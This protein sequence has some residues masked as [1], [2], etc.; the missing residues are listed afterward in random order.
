MNSN[1][2]F[3]KLWSEIKV[4]A[5]PALVAM[6]ASGL[7]FMI[8]GNPDFSGI[9][10]FVLNTL[11][12]ALVI[13]SSTLTLFLYAIYFASS[14]L[15]EFMITDYSIV[16]VFLSFYFAI[17]VSNLVYEKDSKIRKIK[18]LSKTDSYIV[19]ASTLFIVTIGTF[20]IQAVVSSLMHI[21][22]SFSVST[23]P[24]ANS[25]FFGVSSFF[26]GGASY[27][28]KAI[29]DVHD[30]PILDIFQNIFPVVF[31]MLTLYMIS[32]LKS[33]HYNK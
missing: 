33:K 21:L 4:Y 13:I 3:S 20:V 28:K 6:V 14:K 9:T 25:V 31:I 7:F 18:N 19:V 2:F 5:Q 11:L 29:M 17:I 22:A 10:S 27:V 30:F 12:D 23:P 15:Y 16:F 32:L 24:D 1:L 8:T 26:Y